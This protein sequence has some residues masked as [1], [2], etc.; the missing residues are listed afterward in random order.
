[1]PTSS[2]GIIAGERI[3]HEASPASIPQRHVAGETYP[4]RHVAGE[5]PDM[6]P[7]KQAIV[8]GASSSDVIRGSGLQD[9]QAAGVYATGVLHSWNEGLHETSLCTNVGEMTF[10]LKDTTEMTLETKKFP[11][12]GDPFGQPPDVG[13]LDDY[14][15]MDE[16]SAEGQYVGSS[17]TQGVGVGVSRSCKKRRT[18]RCS[19]FAGVGSVSGG[20]DQP[21]FASVGVSGGTTHN[22]AEGTAAPSWLEARYESLLVA[23]QDLQAQVATLH[24]ERNDAELKSNEFQG[25][26]LYRDGNIKLFTRE[27]ERVSKDKGEL[28]K[29]V[30]SLERE[31]IRARMGTR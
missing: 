26:V 19:R 28:Q 29:Q 24:R 13:G 15:T 11:V 27:F 25:M 6:S 23:Y 14:V 9:D 8:V 22:A 2:L 18:I 16:L 30:L 5:S 21:A 7:G 4:Q 31:V 1:G 3:P 20:N 10:L 12:V 17:G